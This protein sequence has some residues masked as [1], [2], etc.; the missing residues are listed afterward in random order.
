MRNNENEIKKDKTASSFYGN[1]NKN[2]FW[3]KIKSIN[4]QKS[5]VCT[6]SIDRITCNKAIVKVF[7]SNINLYLN[8]LFTHKILY[9]PIFISQKMPIHYT[10]YGPLKHKLL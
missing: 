10:L 3:M 6:I 2:G 7:I 4:V 9:I 1:N 8:H 5:D